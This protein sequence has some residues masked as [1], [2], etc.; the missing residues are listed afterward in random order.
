MRLAVFGASGR[1]GVPL[2][3]QALGRGHAVT[4]FVRDRN[5]LPVEHDRLRVVVGDAYTGEGVDEAVADADAV[6]SVMGQTSASPDDLLT[7]AG[8]QI[9]NAMERHGV[10]RFVTLVGAG[11]R[12]EGERVS[13]AGRVIGGL[14]KVLNPAVL[15]D[16][17]NHVEDVR[18]RDLA[19]TVVRAPRLSEGEPRGEYE[20]GDVAPG[21][22]AVSRADVADFVLD[23]IENDWY[24]HNL[25]KITY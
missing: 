16:A 3:E 1:T 9:L 17:E 18:R 6:A 19:W 10:E 7:V 11:V 13:L 25:P 21:R 4:A 22:K 20:T 8:G 23:V 14:L 24:V 5:K 12:V 15:A 2:V